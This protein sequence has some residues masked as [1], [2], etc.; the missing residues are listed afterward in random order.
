MADILDTAKKYYSE[1]LKPQYDEFFNSPTSFRTAFNLVGSLFHF[2]E[3]IY[4]DYKI[5]LEAHFGKTFANKGSFWGAMEATDRRFAFMRD[6][7]NASKHVRLT[8]NPSTSMT[9]VANTAIQIGGFQSNAF[10]RNAFQTSH[11]TMKDGGTEVDFD[12]CAKALFAAW[13]ALINAMQ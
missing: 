5:E 3:W 6:V 11:I 12:D 10:Q 1:V 8:K 9:H 4:E 2:H 7:A 13:T